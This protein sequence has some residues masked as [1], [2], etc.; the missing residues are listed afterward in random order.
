MLF[1][2][3]SVRSTGAGKGAPGPR[4]R[5]LGRRWL[6][7][8]AVV[9]ALLA[10]LVWESDN[11][12]DK[13]ATAPPTGTPSVSQTVPSPYPSPEG[14]TVPDVLG[15]RLVDAEAVLGAEG[16]TTIEAVDASGH[17]RVVVNP[18]NWIVKEQLPAPGT[19]ASTSSRVT[20]KVAKPS[21]GAGNDGSP[22]T[23]GVVPDVVCMDLQ[24]A[25]ERLR[26]AGY[27][28]IR[29]EDG[30]GQG[31]SQ[32]IDRNWVVI[33]QSPAAGSRKKAETPIRLTSVK[34]GEPTGDSGCPY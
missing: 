12:D 29:S 13:A 22:V 3:V 19:N 26:A 9:I 7:F 18:Q 10:Y 4:R 14:L 20:L 27:T 34:Y 8:V 23:Y 33:A 5:L 15:M 21:D 2:N 11:G 31:R 32:I 25:Q 30:L 6:I 24:A 16:F 1:G 28:N 17:G